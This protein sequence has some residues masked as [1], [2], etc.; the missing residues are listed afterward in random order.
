HVRSVS[1]AFGQ[2]L[3]Q[4][5]EPLRDQVESDRPSVRVLANLALHPDGGEFFWRPA[6]APLARLA[7]AVLVERLG[8]LPEPVRYFIDQAGPQKDVVVARPPIA[9]LS[10]PGRRGLA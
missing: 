9:P 2:E 8:H 5:P 10:R 7:E 1:P 3:S 6:G 4:R